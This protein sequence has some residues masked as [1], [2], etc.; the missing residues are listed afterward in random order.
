ME[1]RKAIYSDVRKLRPDLEVEECWD[2][3]DWVDTNVVDNE[4][5]QSA[6][7][8]YYPEQQGDCCG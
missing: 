1:A 6:L 3:L 2:F 8:R 7:S 4:S 5:L